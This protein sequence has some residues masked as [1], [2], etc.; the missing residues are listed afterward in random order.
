MKAFQI[1]GDEN[2]IYFQN[3]QRRPGEEELQEV[4][5][6]LTA[7]GGRLGEKNEAAD[8]DMYIGSLNGIK[9]RLL[10]TGEEAIVCI[11][12]KERAGEILK[13]FE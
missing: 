7:A 11:D 3:L 6:I 8:V 1:S 12:D 2:R 5:E 9:F 10:Y 4:I 13:I